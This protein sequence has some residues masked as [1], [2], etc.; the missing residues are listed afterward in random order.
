MTT[1][2]L[3]KLV[4]TAG[5]LHQIVELCSLIN[6]VGDPWKRLPQLSC[7]WMQTTERILSGQFEDLLYL[8]CLSSGETSM[9]LCG[10]KVGHP[11]WNTYLLQAYFLD[12]EPC[13]MGQACSVCRQ[14]ATL[15]LS[16]CSILALLHTG[17]PWKHRLILKHS[18]KLP[19]HCGYI[20]KLV[21]FF[22]SF[23]GEG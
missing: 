12:C 4:L 23:M 6:A 21:L 5:L 14:L 19:R 20:V 11:G 15:D 10:W 18:G 13:H 2:R 9:W 16:D 7:L 1:M 17:I 3:K 22:P 8:Q